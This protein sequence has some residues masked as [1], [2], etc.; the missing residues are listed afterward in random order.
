MKH[1]V[2]VGFAMSMALAQAACATT[3]QH[4]DPRVPGSG[5][6]GC[7]RAVYQAQTAQLH[8]HAPR[9]D[10]LNAQGGTER[11]LHQ[12]SDEHYAAVDASCSQQAWQTVR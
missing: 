11:V 2:L 5:T 9:G 12:A 7:D 1:F 10:A 6:A 3:A 4:P 8:G